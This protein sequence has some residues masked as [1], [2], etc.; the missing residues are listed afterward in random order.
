M[1]KFWEPGI[2]YGNGFGEFDQPLM[3]SS[4][5]YLIAAEAIL[6]GA[7]NGNVGSAVDYYNRV[8]NRAVGGSTA[9]AD[10]ANDPNNLSS[11]T[12]KSYRAVGSVTIEMIMD[13]R[14]RE[15]M[16]EGLRWYDL[17]RTGTLISRSKAF[18]PWIGA[19]NFIKEHHYLRPIPL[20]EIDL[21][22]NAVSQN[23]GY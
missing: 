3:R 18:N 9:D 13:E 1:W 10:M 4:E 22:N 16:G 7:S 23:P 17:K 21:A 15:L 2:D 19:L 11:T 8:V 14:A 12:A 6:Q 5:A 20:S